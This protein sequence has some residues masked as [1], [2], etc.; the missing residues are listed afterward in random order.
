MPEKDPSKPIDNSKL[1]GGQKPATSSEQVSEGTSGKLDI[2]FLNSQSDAVARNLEA[3][4]W[5]KARI[6][7]ENLEGSKV[8][9]LGKDASGDHDM[10][11]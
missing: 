4:L 8:N 5:Q 3:E 6:F 2:G 9:D 7:L 1:P 10:G 11:N